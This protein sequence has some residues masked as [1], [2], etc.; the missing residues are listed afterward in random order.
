MR[1]LPCSIVSSPVSPAPSCALSA[2]SDA[3]PASSRSLSAPSLA[4]SVSSRSATPIDVC[5]PPSLAS[6][7]QAVLDASAPPKV[8]GNI[9]DL[10]Y[11]DFWLSLNPDPFVLGVLQHG[12]RLP[13]RDSVIPESYREPNNRSALEN[14][15]YL[16]EHVKTLVIDTTTE[17]VFSQPL[18]CSP[19]TV[20]SRYVDSLLRLRMCIDLS[21]IHI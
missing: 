6:L 21:L 18:C 17:E 13:F 14:L 15:P 16:R 1:Y 10:R 12:Y 9:H 4:V 11:R 5:S 3:L 19:L 8:A 2:P 20:A 7:A